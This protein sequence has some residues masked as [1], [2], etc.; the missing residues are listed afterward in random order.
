MLMISPM[1]PRCGAASRL[2]YSLL[3]A[4]MAAG[5]SSVQ[6]AESSFEVYGFAQAD[7]VQDFKRVKPEWDDTLRPS[8]I[9]TTDG[10]YGSDGQSTISVRQS[11]LGVQTT[12]PVEGNSLYTKFEF[13][14]FGVGAD[15]GQ[16]T[17]RLRHAYGEYGNWLAGQTNTLFM[18][19][20]VFPN[21]IDY[22]GPSGMV[23]TRNPQMRWTPVRGD[24]SFA[25]AIEKPSNDIDPGILGISG[26][27]GDE[28]IPDFTAQ[29]RQKTGWG[30]YQ[31][32]GLLR[33]V[34]YETAGTPS[35]NPS[36]SDLGWGVNL[37]GHMM[38]GADK[39]MLQTVYGEGIATYMNDGGTDMG[40]EGVAP[41]I[42]G[43]SL[44]L[45]G[46]VAYYDHY[47]SD[48]LSSSLGY[49]RTQ[50]DNK[51]LQTGDAFKTGEYVSAN[52]LN[53][54]RK[55]MLIGAEALWG[56]RTDKNGAS[57]DDLRVQFTMKYSFS[58]KDFGK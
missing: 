48:K 4:A 56:K 44:P 43:E 36:G 51:N 20:D 32:A 15:E 21:T 54:V 14:M 12:L 27:Q 24:T 58:S 50:V 34:G 53:A 28:K 41:A 57:G 35:A 17:I 23:F 49:S 7:Y 8:R 31:V 29:Y 40:P 38:F 1:P 46:V 9:P 10:Q 39:L 47:W 52:L 30:H 55:N 42:N 19:G 16:T 13:D 25:I 3:V 18:D 2:R 45:L 5:V 11:R 22:W 33:R 26:V 6:A 37:S